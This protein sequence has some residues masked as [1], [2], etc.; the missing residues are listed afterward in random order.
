M[1]VLHGR[2]VVVAQS[3]RVAGV[4]EEVIAQTDVLKIMN[5]RSDV[6]GQQR[7]WV[8]IAG[9][10][11]SPVEQHVQRL[12]HVGGVGAVVVRVLLVAL[13][14]A[15]QKPAQFGAKINITRKKS[16]IR[17][18]YGAIACADLIAPRSVVVSAI[19]TAY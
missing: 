19:H 9:R 16:S 11:P 2:L 8:C 7:H 12:K 4:D 17:S 6:A 15:V 3:Q 14:D 18:Q 10:Q 1:V 13:L 5:D